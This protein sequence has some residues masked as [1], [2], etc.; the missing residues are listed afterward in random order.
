MRDMAE[1]Q[2]HAFGTS[3]PPTGL[4]NAAPFAAAGMGAAVGGMP[5]AVVGAALPSAL[6][7]FGASRLGRRL[8][9]GQTSPQR[10]LA[11]T[12]DLINRPINT[13]GLGGSAAGLSYMNQ[14]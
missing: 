7:A 5:G 9:A 1:A 3:I 13:I 6:T 10:A 2:A 8:F 14:E 11:K 4:A 12:M